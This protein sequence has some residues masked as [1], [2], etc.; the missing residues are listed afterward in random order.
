VSPWQ[1]LGQTADFGP[2]LRSSIYLYFLNGG[3]SCYVLPVG[4][5]QAD[6][7][8]SEA[9]FAQ[10]IATI[11]REPAITLLLPTDAILLPR[12]AYFQFCRELLAY[13]ARSQNRF[14]I[15]DAGSVAAQTY[16]EARAFCVGLRRTGLLMGA[17]YFPAVR[18][19]QPIQDIDGA[20]PGEPSIR[21]AL[22]SAAA[23]AC[24]AVTDRTRG[25]WKAPANLAVEGV[26]ALGVELSL[27]EM[28]DLYMPEDGKS[29]NLVRSIHGRGIYVW[30]GRTLDGHSP[31]WQFVNVRRLVHFVET[32]LRNRTH[33]AAFEP[34]TMRTWII[35]KGIC[36]SFLRGLWEAG[37]LAGAD[38]SAAYEVTVGLG[39][40]MT[41]AE[42]D[43]GQ[44]ILL[45]RIAV[46]QPAEYI[47]LKIFHQ[48]QALGNQ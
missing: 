35:V 1:G 10:V 7:V 32:S 47:T 23:A 28:G 48:V 29:V 2:F 6:Q 42:V 21:L 16:A 43:A 34:N 24:Y 4:L 22:A 12:E 30:G 46:K 44:L 27:E 39:Q 38:Q 15:L 14:C 5:L 33:F 17:A 45:V 13:A 36:D 9:D 18:L 40:S 37:G 3:G 20:A 8:P 41:Q 11:D 19:Q 31:D 25:V 26:L